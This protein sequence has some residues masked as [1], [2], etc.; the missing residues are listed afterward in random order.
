MIEKKKEKC[1]R[2]TYFGE[3]DMYSNHPIK[4]PSI[5]RTFTLLYPHL[6]EKHLPAPLAQNIID[7]IW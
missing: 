7:H 6:P 4:L 2:W 1:T 3:S 5:V